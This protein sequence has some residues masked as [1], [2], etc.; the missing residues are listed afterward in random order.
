MERQTRDTLGKWATVL[1]KR[2]QKFNGELRIGIIVKLSLAVVGQ[3]MGN[4]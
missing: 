2:A 4:K 1:A 3:F